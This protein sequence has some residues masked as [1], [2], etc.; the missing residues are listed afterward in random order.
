MSADPRLRVWAAVLCT[1]LLAPLA[2][3]AEPAPKA[4]EP[5]APK[6]AEKD[7]KRTTELDK[8]VVTAARG[9]RD[10]ATVPNDLVVITRAD[11]AASNAKNVPDL[12]RQE[13]GIKV[14]DLFGDGSQVTVDLLGFGPTTGTQSLNTLVLIDGQRAN[15]ADQATVNWNAIPLASIERIEVLRGGGGVLYG[16]NASGGVVN[17]I[18]RRGLGNTASAKFQVDSYGG[19]LG[20]LSLSAGRP[21]YSGLVAQTYGQTDGY[22]ANN[23]HR[24]DSTHG[25][26][27]LHPQ[28]SA[29]S[30]DV[31]AGRTDEDFGLPGSL[32]LAQLATT[33]DANDSD[34]PLNNGKFN[35]VYANVIPKVT[36]GGDE[37]E[38][39]LGLSYRE[40]E[41]GARYVSTFGT[42]DVADRHRLWGVAP[43]YTWKSELCGHANTLTL[44]YDHYEDEL[45]GIENRTDASQRL[46]EYFIHD[47]F[48]LCEQLYLDLGYRHGQVDY[49]FEGLGE[50]NHNLDAATVGL[51]WNY[52][53]DSKVFASFDRS[54][55]TGVL[56]ESQVFDF[57]TYNMVLNP[58]LRPQISETWQAG[59]RHHFDDRFVPS[60]TY[61]HVFTRD[62]IFYDAATFMNTNYSHT[63]RR[64]VMAAAD[65]RLNQYVSGFA[66]YTYLD[67]R[68]GENEEGTSYDGKRIPMTA[69]HT[70]NIGV[71]FTCPQGFALDVLGRWVN[72]QYTTSDWNNR[73]T[74]IPSFVTV[75][76]KLSYTWQWLTVFVGVNN[77]FDTNYYE[78]ATYGVNVY[79]APQRNL[80]AGFAV[81]QTF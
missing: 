67:A 32:T 21:D 72:T 30:L 33:W 39:A 59:V 10:A 68:L 16:D 23:D 9:E 51:T 71:R 50:V 6:A 2:P 34:E 27:S 8:M 15:F 77:L 38:V 22:R 46:D 41:S 45:N 40:R 79:P 62:E 13:A 43:Q 25:S 44:G 74:R 37:H 58:N 55:R 29:Y 63:E 12:L 56:D 20:S 61:F 47:S 24:I 53:P 48:E 60:L 4:V 80:F 35:T 1:V 28:Q 81:E 19:Y 49:D 18:T 7:E 73:L 75:D 66:N 78:Y 69:E 54:Y 17:I 31:Q 5:A 65:S 57:M 52:Q 11:I 70:A 36:F 64:G 42:Y 76:S 26:L 3:A 14:T